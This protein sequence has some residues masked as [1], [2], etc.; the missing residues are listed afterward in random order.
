MVLGPEHTYK[1]SEHCTTWTS[2]IKR[3]DR[4]TWRSKHPLLTGHTRSDK[5]NLII[6]YLFNLM[7]LILINNLQRFNWKETENN[8]RNAHAQPC[9]HGTGSTACWL[10]ATLWDTFC[11]LQ[12]TSSGVFLSTKVYNTII[13]IFTGIQN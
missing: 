8:Y 2:E 11:I 13:F 10:S 7:I 4:V 6:N 12:G 3:W 1:F 9:R 5:K